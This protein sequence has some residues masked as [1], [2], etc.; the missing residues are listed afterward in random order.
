MEFRIIPAGLGP[1]IASSNQ[2]FRGNW[3]HLPIGPAIKDNPNNVAVTVG[4]G[5][6]F[7]QSSN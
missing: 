6:V 2:R 5:E 7:A 3:A 4:I 1:S